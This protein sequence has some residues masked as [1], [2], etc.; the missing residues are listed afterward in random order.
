MVKIRLTDASEVDELMTAD[1]YE[2][3]VQKEA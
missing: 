1:D 2:D 3:Y